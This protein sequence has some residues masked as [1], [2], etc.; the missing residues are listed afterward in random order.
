MPIHSGRRHHLDPSARRLYLAILD[1]VNDLDFGLKLK[2]ARAFKDQPEWNAL[3]PD[4]QAVF[5]DVAAKVR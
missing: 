3:D 5:S 4:L 2:F 1:T